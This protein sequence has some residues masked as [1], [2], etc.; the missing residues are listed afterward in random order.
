MTTVYNY[1]LS[2]DFRGYLIPSWV[3]QIE[4]CGISGLTDYYLY[5]S[6]VA[7]T[8]SIIF[9]QAITKSD[10]DNQVAIAAQWVSINKSNTDFGDSS[11]IDT[12]QLKAELPYLLPKYG[13]VT[14]NGDNTYT[15]YFTSALTSDETTSFNNYCTNYSYDPGYTTQYY[16]ANTAIQA[17]CTSSTWQTIL[18]IP[19][20]KISIN[21]LYKC[22][23]VMQLNSGTHY[24]VQIVDLTTNLVLCNALTNTNT[25]YAVVTSSEVANQSISNS[26]GA[27]QIQTDGSCSIESIGFA[28][29][30]YFNQTV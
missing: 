23:L 17:T 21:Q 27:L 24:D 12:T 7:D 30:S 3:T 4:N 11:N 18:L 16:Y 5:T 8:V 29:V 9:S 2:T 19:L 15:F 28:Y 14:N 1:S 13:S 6:V 26:V 22:Y 20:P 25:S 10:L